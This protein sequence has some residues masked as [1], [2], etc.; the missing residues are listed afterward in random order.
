[1]GFEDKSSATSN[2]EEQKYTKRQ[3]PPQDQD[4]IHMQIRRGSAGALNHHTIPSNELSPK[5]L[6]VQHSHE[7]LPSYN[8]ASQMA[9]KENQRRFN[10]IENGPKKS[11][12]NY[13]T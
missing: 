9:L 4:P 6:P 3:G 12:T 7:Y 2:N 11:P 10:S 1:M 5:H 13:V 8:S